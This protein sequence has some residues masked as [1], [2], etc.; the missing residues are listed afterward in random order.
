MGILLRLLSY[1]RRRASMAMAAA[2]SGLLQYKGNFTSVAGRNGAD[3]NRALRPIKA[4]YTGAPESIPVN[5]SFSAGS[6]AGFKFGVSRS[7]SSAQ[8]CKC[9]C[10]PF[11]AG[12]LVNFDFLR[13][14]HAMG[15]FWSLVPAL[16][17]PEQC[18]YA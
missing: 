5:K 13:V 7:R 16:I 15:T 8:P 11:L 3:Q 18:L 14:Q 6:F 2:K 12:L 4:G 9:N 10:A 17:C 1:E